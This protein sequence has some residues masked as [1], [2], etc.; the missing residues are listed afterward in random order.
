MS[1]SNIASKTLRI[2]ALVAA[3]LSVS[4]GL[5]ACGYTPLYAHNANSQDTHTLQQL[6][7]IS[8]SPIPNREG[9][10]MRSALKRRL[11]VRPGQ[12]VNYVL[13]V[14]LSE[15]IGEIAVDSGSF[16]TRANLYLNASYALSN[17]AGDTILTQGLAQSVAS[18]NILTSDY[19]NYVARQ[20]ARDRAIQNLADDIRNRIAIHFDAGPSKAK[21]VQP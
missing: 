10:L 13:S 20:D 5:S 15:S 4:A 2:C 14:Q 19:A 7:G 21:I 16:S 8:V 6:A 17:A 18:Y 3:V 11:V 12:P 9:Q 1:L